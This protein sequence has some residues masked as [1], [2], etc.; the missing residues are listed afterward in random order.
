MQTT[1][2]L[3]SRQCEEGFARVLAASVRKSTLRQCEK[4]LRVTNGPTEVAQDHI[5]SKWTNTA[6]VPKLPTRMKI[7]NHATH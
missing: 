2:I 7:F 6:D 1:R 4:G 5:T 3:R